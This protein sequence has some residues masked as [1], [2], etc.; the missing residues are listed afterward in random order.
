MQS[1]SIIDVAKPL[2]YVDVK[3]THSENNEA[4]DHLISEVPGLAHNE[5]PGSAEY[6]NLP[7]L[8]QA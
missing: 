3:S 5:G 6:S 7:H 2:F 4:S 8:Q 1:P